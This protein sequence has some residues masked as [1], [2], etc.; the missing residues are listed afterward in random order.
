MDSYEAGAFSHAQSDEPTSGQIVID[1]ASPVAKTKLSVEERLDRLSKYRI[2]PVS[3]RSTAKPIGCG[4]KAEVVRA[5]FKRNKK[6]RGKRVAVK[7]VRCSHDADKGKFAKEFLNEVE[8]LAALSHENIVQLIGFVENLKHDKAWI[9][10][11]WEPNGN[12]REFLASGEW[13]IPERLS[14]IKDTF[15]GLGYLHTREPPVCH[16]DLK[17]LNILVTS[18]SR[19]VITDFGSARTLNKS[20]SRAASNGS[21]PLARAIP[22]A[23]RPCIDV[24]MIGDEL[25]LTGPAWSLRWAAPEV[26]K[27]EDPPGLPSDIW[28]AGWVCWEIMTDKLPFPDVYSEGPLTLRVLQG[29]VPLAHEETQLAQVVRLCSL[30]SD[31]WKFDPNR[32]P[33]AAQCHR[34]MAWLPSTV[35]IGS[36]IPSTK[37][38]LQMGRLEHAKNRHE[39]AISFFRQVLDTVGGDKDQETSAAALN[40]LGSVY[41]AQCADDKAEESFVQAADIYARIGNHR[42]HANSLDWLGD[43]CRTKS[44]YAEAQ[45]YLLQAQNIYARISNSQGRANTLNGLGEVYYARSKFVEAE[46]SFIQARDIHASIGNELGRANALDGLGDISCAQ[47]NYTQAEEHY[48]QARNIYARIGDDQGEANT[49]L[50]LGHVYYAQAKYVEAEESFANAQEAFSRTGDD[51]GRANALRGLGDVHRNQKRKLEAASFY[52]A[53]KN[54][55]ARLGRSED[56]AH[57]SRWL[58]PSSLASMDTDFTSTSI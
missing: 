31:C 33:K 44:K 7:K 16:G 9:V 19:A 35:P 12:V 41:Y 27:E 47:S 5:H 26:V 2:R 54:L 34:E 6:A 53:A 22:T 48:T 32:R 39:K 3:I 23:T 50:G 18:S 20:A 4:G 42:G 25:T 24:D 15:A 49:F 8:M 45:T 55:Y 17:S 14:L 1:G 11:S 58:T 56:E 36:K 40:L 10:L 57:I 29:K 51:Q 38:L 13:E 43:I 30:M 46:E 21:V 52:G 28:S 37:L